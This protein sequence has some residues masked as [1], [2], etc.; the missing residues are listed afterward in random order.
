MGSD[1]CNTRVHGSARG[2]GFSDSIGYLRWVSA[3]VEVAFIRRRCAR[4]AFTARFKST[5]ALLHDAF[6][7][8]MRA[9][10]RITTYIQFDLGLMP[11]VRVGG[12]S[13]HFISVWT[14]L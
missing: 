2:A 9:Q 4:T 12:V 3:Y 1:A 7:R 5:C 6:S 11:L 14:S 10:R 8:F 13:H